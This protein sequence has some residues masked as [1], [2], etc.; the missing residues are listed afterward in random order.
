MN[1]S[2]SL[3][4]ILGKGRKVFCLW[5]KVHQSLS[6]NVRDTVLYHAVFRLSTS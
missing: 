1:Y 4:L 5:T 2:Y 3:Y 6:A